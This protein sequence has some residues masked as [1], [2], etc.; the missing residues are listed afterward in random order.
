[1]PPAPRA[2]T[3]TTVDNPADGHLVGLL[4]SIAI[5]ADGLPIISYYD[6]TGHAVKVAKCWTADCQA[7][8]ATARRLSVSL[9]G[10]G[11]G[12]VSSST[13]AG[14][15]ACGATC[16]ASFQTG[17]P[18]T[19]TAVAAPGSTFTGWHR[20][21]CPGVGACTVTMTA[22]TPVTAT[23]AITTHPVPGRPTIATVDFDGAGGTSI[24]IGTDGLPV[25]AYEYRPGPYPAS[26][27]N[28]AKCADPACIGPSTIT[29]VDPG[30]GSDPSIAIGADGF[31]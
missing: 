14:A 2:G 1:M 28:V 25:I 26:A 4:P 12:T 22:D 23:F 3:I 20:A 11:S 27:L 8:G 15:I 29:V 6:D 10:L 17:T 13:P 18:V 5:G 31:P 9:A 19:L 16:D 7:A 30:G 24:A 21:D